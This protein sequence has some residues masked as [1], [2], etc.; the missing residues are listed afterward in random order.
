MAGGGRVKSG[1]EATQQKR[2]CEQRPGKFMLTPSGGVQSQ[3]Q[4]QGKEIP[5]IL[6]NCIFLQ[7]VSKKLEGFS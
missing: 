4:L 7:R 3:L 2:L 1:Q 5:F 6:L